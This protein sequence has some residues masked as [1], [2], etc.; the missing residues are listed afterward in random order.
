MLNAIKKGEV[1][2][3]FVFNLDKKRRRNNKNLFGYR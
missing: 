1:F 2:T 3:L